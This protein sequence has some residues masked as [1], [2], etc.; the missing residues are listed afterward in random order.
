[1]GKR[2]IGGE[3]D[4]QRRRE[5]PDGHEKKCDSFMSADKLLVELKAKVRCNLNEPDPAL[6]IT[7]MVSTYLTVLRKF[8]M[9]NLYKDS[10]KLA[11]EHLVELVQPV[12]LQ[13]VLRS[14][15][16]L[17]HKDLKKNF[18]G[19]QPSLVAAVRGWRKQ[20]FRRRGSWKWRLYKQVD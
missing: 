16:D 1:M 10:P 9:P 5:V 4:R 18:S 15:R 2:R 20:S 6:R 13:D 14:D 19:L 12:G 7:Q 17:Q 11:T 3:V 8:R